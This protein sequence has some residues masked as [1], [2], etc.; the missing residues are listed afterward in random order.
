ML[1]LSVIALLKTIVLGE[2]ARLLIHCPVVR[3]FW[4]TAH[5]QQDS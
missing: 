5:Y 4:L 2:R 1:L 3:D